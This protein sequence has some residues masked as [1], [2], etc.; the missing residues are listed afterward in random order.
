L[1]PTR[2]RLAQVL[3]DRLRFDTFDDKGGRQTAWMIRS[4]NPEQLPQVQRV[5]GNPP[6]APSMDAK[7]AVTV[8][9][10]SASPSTSK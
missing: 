2:A 4:A 6:A 10:L 1:A 7:P 5:S 8:A 9:P 3:G